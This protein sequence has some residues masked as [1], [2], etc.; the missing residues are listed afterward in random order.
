MPTADLALPWKSQETQA[1]M[2]Q[3]V[4]D[5]DLIRRLQA[6][7]DDAVRDL[8]AQYGQRLYAYALRLTN[9]PATAEDITQNTLVTAWRTARTFRGEGRLIAWLLGIVHHTAMKAIRNSTNYLDD[10]AEET[11][12]EDQPSPEEQAQVKDERRWVRQGIQS[13]SSEHRAVLELVF[14]QELSLNEAAQVLNIPVGTVKSR[15]SYARNHLR[16]VLARTEER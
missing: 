1:A 5:L 4:D 15:L 7:D 11:I 13:L 8:Y 12:S 6:G 16:G 10:V 9:D 2:T 3:P 14:Y